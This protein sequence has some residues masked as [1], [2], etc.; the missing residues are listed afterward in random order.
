MDGF[1]DTTALP[2]GARDALRPDNA[3][4]LEL[5]RSYA[6]LDSPL[7]AHTQWAQ[8]LSTS[9]NDLRWFRGDN[10]Y[11]WQYSRSPELNRLRYFLYASY[12]RGVDAR[13]LLEGTLTEDGAFGCFTFDYVNV[14]RVSRDLLDSVNE[15]SFLDRRFGLFDRPGTRILDIGAGYGRL[16]ERTLTALPAVERYTCVDAVPRSTFLCRYYLGER[17]HLGAGGRGE[18]VDLPEVWERVARGSVDLAVNVHSFSEMG[19]TAVRG[20]LELIAEKDVPWLFVVP[21]E[22]SA[23]LSR[24]LDGSRI[25][26]SDLLAGAGYELHHHEPTIADPDVRALFG[27]NDEFLL[28]QRTL[29]PSAAH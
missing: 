19:R 1:D 15:L 6:A 3:L 17:G 13:S 8:A 11:L 28:Y 23:L 5:E 12:V 22:G 21:N 7:N 2:P 26:C 20:W 29:G 4:L 24:E 25:D 9:V 18:V 14:P 10:A 16:A 27:V